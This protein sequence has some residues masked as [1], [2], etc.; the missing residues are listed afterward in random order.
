M[1]Q[2]WLGIASIGALAFASSPALADAPK[3][4]AKPAQKD[5]ANEREEA[6]EHEETSGV[7]YADFVQGFGKVPLAVQ[8]PTSTAE[9]LP[10]THAGAGPITTESF[11]VG[12]MFELLPK[13]AFGARVP[14]TFATL[15]PDGDADRGTAAF[16]NLELLAEHEIHA[17]SYLTFV[18]EGGV[19]LPTANG[20]NMP[21]SLDTLS[22]ANVDRA[23]YDKAAINRAASL[24]RGG[25][26]TALYA[27]N[28]LGVN[29]QGGAIW[30]RGNLKISGMAKI[31]NLFSTSS[32]NAHK[33]V[34]ELVPKARVS[35]RVSSIEPA[36]AAYAP[37][38]FAG[39]E[40]GEEKVGVVVE[41][42]VVGYFGALRPAL[43]VVVP[44]AG[45]AAD[46]QTL[47]V[48]LALAAV[49]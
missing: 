28:Y 38:A 19:S 39:A 33:Y 36:L 1:T 41:P 37:I 13:T 49:F 4:A 42:Q 48:R 43:G 46:P 6:P 22:P 17:Q 15:H 31:E 26:D 5:E 32:S 2:K 27:L 20:A 29:P 30:T 34:G 23:G 12:A 44:V 3:P 9:P 18:I 14:F 21:D 47:G 25:E 24:A 35:Y 16:G 7:V 45:P 40:T 10:R 11:I 8:N